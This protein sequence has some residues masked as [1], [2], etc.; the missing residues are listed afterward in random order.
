MKG[1]F[2]IM[3]H[4]TEYTHFIH[5]FFRL[6]VSMTTEQIPS[7]DENHNMQFEAPESTSVYI[8]SF[9]II[10]SNYVVKIRNC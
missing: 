10:L 2:I 8:L 7:A 5:R 1:I 9:D 3:K 6:C 4:F